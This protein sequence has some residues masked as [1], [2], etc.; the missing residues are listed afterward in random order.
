MSLQ[1][2]VLGDSG[3]QLSDRFYSHEAFL[4]RLKQGQESETAKV[5]I[6]G[7]S[8]IFTI[9]ELNRVPPRKDS[10]C[11]IEIEGERQGP[12]Y[13]MQIRNMCL[14][15]SLTIDAII[16]WEEAEARLDELANNPLFFCYASIEGE[17]WTYISHRFFAN[18][19]S[20]FLGLSVGFALNA[21]P[22]VISG[23]MIG[24]VCLGHIVGAMADQLN[25]VDRQLR[26]IRASRQVPIRP[27]LTSRQAAELKSAT[28]LCCEHHERT[29]REPQVV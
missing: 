20:L 15:G 26:G 3:K 25:Y 2:R 27:L 13:P 12:Y 14:N 16:R 4:Q 8:R 23:L 9:A 24:A 28:G 18:V 1:Y 19:G 17:E 29:S 22:L 7:Y 10:E 21:H 5:V 6:S 11:Y